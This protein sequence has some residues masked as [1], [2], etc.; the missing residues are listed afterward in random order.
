[1]TSLRAFLH[2]LN[3]AA[4]TKS[5]DQWRKSCFTE[6][7]LGNEQTLTEKGVSV[8]K[9]KVRLCLQKDSQL[10]IVHTDRLSAFDRH[11]DFVP[12]KGAILCA[13]SGY[14]FNYI[15]DDFPT[16]FI[17]QVDGRSLL[18]KA[19]EPVKAEVIVRT[20]LAG[21]ILRAY[22]KGE[23]TFC[24][25]TLP[26]DLKPYA[27]FPEPII[28]PTTKAE[29]FAHDENTTAEELI[30]KGVCSQVEWSE[31]SSLAF[32][33]FKA[34]EQVYKKNGWLLADTKYEF[35]RDANGKIHIIDE[36]HT[37]DSSRLW[38]QTSY[39]ERLASGKPPEML[40]KENVRSYLLAKGFQGKGEVPEVPVKEI[41]KLAETY[42]DVAEALT[43]TELSV[44]KNA[45]S[46]IL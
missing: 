31:I 37:P 30:S 8:Y 46:L 42:L 12:Q 44:C 15:K 26:N 21:S 18:V 11:I 40:D 41:T 6:E 23:R 5:S 24:G 29:A 45:F 27:P 43:K 2:S 22:E 39:Q 10:Q 38:K 3:P 17:R 16:H 4:S 33:L 34:G 7:D 20:Y 35:G 25:V 28:T 1:M 13:I 19:M 14:W 32:E 9:G 36:I